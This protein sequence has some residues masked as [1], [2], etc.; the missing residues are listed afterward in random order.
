MYS[1]LKRAQFKIRAAPKITLQTAQHHTAWWY[2]LHTLVNKTSA[3]SPACRGVKIFWSVFTSRPQKEAGGSKS[4]K[5]ILHTFAKNVPSLD[6]LRQADWDS[7]KG[8]QQESHPFTQNADAP[9]ASA[10]NLGTP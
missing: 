10:N 5:E 9:V 3:L 2:M 1:E 8:P 7:G 6:D 4:P